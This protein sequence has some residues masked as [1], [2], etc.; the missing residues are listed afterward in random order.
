MR[1]S[2]QSPFRSSVLLASL[3][4]SACTPQ[5][6]TTEPVKNGAFRPGEVQHSRNDSMPGVKV[7]TMTY[8]EGKLSGNLSYTYGVG[9]VIGGVSGPAH[10]TVWSFECKRDAMTDRKHCNLSGTQEN[11]PA[12]LGGVTFYGSSSSHL[13]Q[14]CV[15]GNDFP[16]RSAMIRF[17]S[18]PAMTT[19]QNGCISSPSLLQRALRARIIHTRYVHWP[20]EAAEDATVRTTGLA[21]ALEL[22]KFR[23]K[24]Q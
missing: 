23:D 7:P 1:N 14:M 2:S 18:G 10:M 5:Y 20:Y 24:K 21:Q 19:N 9:D 6:Q 4:F 13:F 12:S 3:C 15:D 22:M 8:R 16:G 11:G 17:D